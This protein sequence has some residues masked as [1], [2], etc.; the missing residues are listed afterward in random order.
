V[1][2]YPKVRLNESLQSA[3]KSN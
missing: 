1:V 3:I 2:A